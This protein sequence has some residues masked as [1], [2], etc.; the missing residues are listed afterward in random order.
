MRF[1]RIHRPSSDEQGSTLVV[2]MMVMGVVTTLSILIVT[3]AIE[4]G[5]TTGKD[6]GRLV[7]VN[8]AEASID[9][10]YAAIQSSGTT[11]PCAWPASGTQSVQSY[12]ETATTYAT[13]KYYDAAGA[14]MSCSG[15]LPAGATPA[16]AVIEGFGKSGSGAAAPRKMQAL[17]N[18][19]PVS[20]NGFSNA[21][22]GQAVVNLSNN[23][24]V[25]N[26]GGQSA[27][28]YT[29]GN[30]DCQNSASFGGSIIAPNGY[31]AMNNSCSANGNVLAK[32]NIT[33]MNRSTIGGA[34]RSSTASITLA[35]Q[36]TVQGTL[37]AAGGISWSGCSASP[38]KCQSGV[39]AVP[40]PPST[41][42][43]IIRGDTASWVAQG[44]TVTAIPTGKCDVDAGFWVKTQAEIAGGK[45]LYTTD[46][47]VQFQQVDI[48]FKHDVAIFAKGGIT[49]KESNSFASSV[50]GTTRNVQLIIPY[51]SVSVRPCDSPAMGPLNNFSSTIDISLL[52]YSPCDIS[53]ANSGGSYGQVYSG[54]TLTTNNNFT[55][56]YRQVPVWGVDPASQPTLSYK[57][58]VVYKRED[59]N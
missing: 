56:T 24:T 35:G 45:A 36:T 54:S 10:A 20:S 55:L 34:V 21:L 43:P 11:L 23:A 13:I 53:Y 6:R 57:V 52:W 46:C 19:T 18:L 22:F 58:D 51:D 5:R 17:A 48:L 49:T 33:T 16:R 30:F 8:A 32:G 50:A 40:S 1:Q 26:S 31:I 7:A 38:G 12:P 15:T 4:T 27:D 42:F 39:S 59:M 25:L 14:L 44:Y 3:V 41:P 28:I 37:T 29:N 9:A 47:A 2:A